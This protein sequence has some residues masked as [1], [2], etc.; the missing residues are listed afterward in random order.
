MVRWDWK[1]PYS[2]LG[3]DGRPPGS[4]PPKPSIAVQALSRSL[5][6][7]KT[8]RGDPLAEKTLH[9]VDASQSAFTDLATE[10]KNAEI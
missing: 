3:A 10:C 9:C 5:V 6:R 8:M 7:L 1:W 4:S 2:A